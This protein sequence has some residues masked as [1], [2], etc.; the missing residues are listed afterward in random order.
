M[1]VISPRS[2]EALGQ[3]HGFPA[4]VGVDDRFEPAIGLGELRGPLLDQALQI[5]MR[6]AQRLFGFSSL[7]D[8]LKRFDSTDDLAAQGRSGEEQPAAALAENVLLVV[9]QQQHAFPSRRKFGRSA[10]RDIGFGAAR[11]HCCCCSVAG[12]FV[13]GLVCG[14][15]AKAMAVLYGAR[16]QVALA[17]GVWARARNRASRHDSWN[18]VA[19][20]QRAEDAE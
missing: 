10:N 15:R 1:T 20:A 14:R 3:I 17:R 6:L 2:A 4:A 13:T 11:A 19:A 5:G 16:P 8:V 18:I 12:D 9:D 7:G